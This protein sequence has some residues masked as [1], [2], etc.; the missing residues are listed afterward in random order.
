MFYMLFQGG[1]TSIM[2]FVM[3]SLLALYWFISLLG[4]RLKTRGYRSLSVKEEREPLQAGNQVRIQFRMEPPR[5]LPV[6]YVIVREVLV[7]HSGESWSF[8]ES[9]V[10]NVRSG[11][12]LS[13][14]TPP[15]ER[16]TYSFAATELVYE[17]IFGLVEHKRTIS[18]PGSFQVLPRTVFIPRWQLFERGHRLAGPEDHALS[19]RET[20]QTSGVRDYVP[21]DRITRIHWNATAKTGSLKSKEFEHEAMP[22]TM[23]VLD[24]A[25]DSYPK[26]EQFELAV[27][28]AA[29]LLDY[30]ARNRISMGLCTLGARPAVFP[31]VPGPYHRQEM[32][33]HLVDLMPEGEADGHSYLESQAHQFRRGSLLVYISSKRMEAASELIHF[34]RQRQLP[35]YHIQIGSRSEPGPVPGRG[36]GSGLGA[37]SGAGIGPGIGS[38][39]GS[40]YGSG[41]GLAAAFPSYSSWG[42]SGIQGSYVRSLEELPAAIGGAR[43]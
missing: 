23:L 13:Y 35:F 41:P 11:G 22:K 12:E 18:I 20:T 6:P 19:R 43:L 9:V 5:F 4:T 26:L 2:L 27:S 14:Q 30:G 15:L 17:D 36:S 7:R 1:K 25:K 8:E 28:T 31:P 32:L 42:Y 34:A 33:H 10:P 21:G 40:G 24:A 29:S 39:F 37:G 16:G 3:V 38:G